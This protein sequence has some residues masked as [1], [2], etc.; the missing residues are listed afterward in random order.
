ML[1]THACL[2][3][4]HA[5]IGKGES[6]MEGEGRKADSSYVCT[7]LGTISKLYSFNT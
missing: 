2:L 1:I 4:V 5:E 6:I 7:V 3:L